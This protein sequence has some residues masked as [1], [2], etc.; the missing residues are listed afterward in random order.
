MPLSGLKR[1]RSKFEAPYFAMYT[2]HFFAQNFERKIRMHIIY[3]YNDYTPW[4]ES[5]Y[6]AQKNM[7]AR[8]TWLNTVRVLS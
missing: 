8:I 4:A 1:P 6:D 5:M 7:G 3:V 2:V